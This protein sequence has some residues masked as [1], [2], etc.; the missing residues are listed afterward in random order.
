MRQEQEG[1]I[2][3]EMSSPERASPT[4]GEV[5]AALHKQYEESFLYEPR[6][7][8][9]AWEQETAIETA[10]ADAVPEGSSIDAVECRRTVCKAEISFNE[11][12]QHEAFLS[13]IMMDDAFRGGG[14]EG[15]K[16]PVSL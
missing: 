7:A 2:T 12:G 3:N 6:D 9:W 5:S 10:I 15:M 13:R 14:L 16:W 8:S 4:D 11:P 1:E